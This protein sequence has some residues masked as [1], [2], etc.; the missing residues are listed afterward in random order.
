MFVADFFVETTQDIQYTI[1]VAVVALQMPILK[2]PCRQG[3]S[4]KRN[5]T[6]YYVGV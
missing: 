1:S 4:I 5:S 2:Y 3:C 6:V